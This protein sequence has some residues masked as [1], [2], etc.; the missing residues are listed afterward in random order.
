MAE[1]RGIDT[2][3]IYPITRSLVATDIAAVTETPA[4]TGTLPLII[5]VPTLLFIGKNCNTGSVPRSKGTP[6][7]SRMIPTLAE[8]MPRRSMAC[9]KENTGIARDKPLLGSFANIVI[10][11]SGSLVEYLIHSVPLVAGGMKQTFSA[12]GMVACCYTFS[13]PVSVPP[14]SCY[15]R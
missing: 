13:T 11:S 12:I 6:P 8:C 14:K 7:S 10:L 4:K 3:G 5:T 9:Y 2:R 15:T 1:E